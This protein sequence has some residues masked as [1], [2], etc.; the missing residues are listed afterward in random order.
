[1]AAIT[2]TDTNPAITKA[3]G[4]GGRGSATETDPNPTHTEAAGG[5]RTC[6]VKEIGVYGWIITGANTY[7]GC[8]VRDVLTTEK[9]VPDGGAITVIYTMKSVE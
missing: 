3:T 2:I 1:M 9:D 4:G 5:G 8:F 6:R 7:Y